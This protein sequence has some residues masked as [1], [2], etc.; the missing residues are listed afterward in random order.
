MLNDRGS[1]RCLMRSNSVNSEG[2]PEPTNPAPGGD[3]RALARYVIAATLVRS[4]DGGAVVAIVL[5]AHTSGLSGWMSGVLGAAITAPHMLG[6]LIAR[7]LDTAHDARKVIALAAIAH[8]VL[9]AAAALL[10]PSAA[11]VFP[12]LLLVVSGL[13]GP[14]LYGGI[15]SRLP[16]IAGPSQ[17]S[18]RRAQGWDVASYGFAGT[19]GPAVVALVAGLSSPLAAT[20]ILA[21]AAVAGAGAVFILPRAAAP[22]RSVSVPSPVRTLL[23]I[24]KSGPLRRTLLLTISVSFAVASLP[25]YAVAIAPTLG[26]PEVAGTLVAGYGVGSLIGSGLLMLWPLRGEADRLNV[27]L[28]GMVAAAL[29]LVIPMPSLT[30]TLLAFA[31]A[32]ISNSLFFGATLAARNEYAQ[33]E[34]R[35]QVFIWVGALKIA[36]AS[37]GT[38]I[39][40]IFIGGA[41][42]LPV[43]IVVALVAVVALSTGVERV[44]RHG[45]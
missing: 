26:G 10:I 4:A 12:I 25:I 20:L 28:A 32:G 18:Q 35:G 16:S 15:S 34:S 30:T 23:W 44:V 39:A 41:A 37:A 14:M 9:L 11:I 21:A 3:A 33:P 22:A 6:P 2:S 7:R 5:L 19:I 17:R 45:A 8:G 42:W 36:S 43:A 29:L 24:W 31:V 40:G 13:F 38:A 1:P 27:L